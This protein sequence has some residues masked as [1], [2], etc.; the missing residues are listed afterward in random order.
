MRNINEGITACNRTHTKMGICLDKYGF[1]E[2]VS[3]GRHEA[4]QICSFDD[5]YHFSRK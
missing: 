4:N 3:S 1:S 2:N 5:I